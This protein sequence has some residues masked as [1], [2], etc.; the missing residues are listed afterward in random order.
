M[1]ANRLIVD[2]GGGTDDALALA[3]LVTP[4]CLLPVLNIALL[5]GGADLDRGQFAAAT[6]G[7]W[8]VGV[9]FC[10]VGLYAASLSPQTGA[11]VIT[12]FAI[13]LVFSVIGRVETLDTDLRRILAGIGGAAPGPIAPAGPPATHAA[14]RLRD[15]YDA[16]C[17]ALVEQVY[18][19]D[20]AA[21]GY[22]KGF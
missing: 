12:A 19:A 17:R 8:L 15:H 2:T 4:L 14:D 11:S 22:P 6:L 1:M 20:F 16:E 7:L 10:A 9:M 21:F 18:A 3:L 5:A 13:L